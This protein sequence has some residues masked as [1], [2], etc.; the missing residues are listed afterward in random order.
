MRLSLLMVSP[1]V[2]QPLDSTAII[3]V[4]FVAD[5]ILL[6]EVLMVFLGGIELRGHHYLRNDRLCEPLRSLD[7]LFGSIRRTFLFIGLKEKAERY[8]LPCRRTVR[9]A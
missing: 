6:V 5:R 7:R 3:L 2:L 8:P 1:R 4:E 9:S